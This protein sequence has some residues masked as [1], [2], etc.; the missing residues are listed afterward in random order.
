MK[1]LIGIDEAGRGPLAGPVA[2]GA[3]IVPHRFDWGLVTGA[4]DS[5][6]MTPASREAL[7]AT[8]TALRKAG[9]L[10]FAVAFCAASVIDGRGI[11][12][13]IQSAL[14]R[15]LQK[16]TENRSLYSCEVRLDG[17]LKAPSEFVHQTTIIRGDISEP[18]I[19]LAS[20]AAKVERDRLM[21][22]MAKRYPQYRF[23]VH[24]GYGTRDH[25]A[26]IARYG[27]CRLHRMSFCTALPNGSNAV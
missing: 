13:A 19:S 7:Y 24:K 12:P 11:V 17:S 9:K 22:R 10:N 2:V 21:E 23:E 20:I 6:Q 4:R 25:R 16:V 3:V 26:R 5:K 15:A 1:Y 8:M 14:N 27:F 18:V